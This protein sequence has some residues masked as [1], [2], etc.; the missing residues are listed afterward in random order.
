VAAET[1]P[2]EAATEA[3]ADEEPTKDELALTEEEVLL[4][5]TIE[6]ELDDPKLVEVVAFVASILV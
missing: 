1:K 3:V 6:L 5:A 2:L 4:E